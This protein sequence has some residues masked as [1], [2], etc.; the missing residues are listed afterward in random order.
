MQAREVINANH[1]RQSAAR[2]TALLKVLSNPDRL[3]ILCQLTVSEYSV[4][5][6]EGNTGV[7]QP[8]LSQQLGILR[9][10]KLVSTRRVGKQIFYRLVSDDAYA[11][12][13]LLDARF[14]CHQENAESDTSSSNTENL[15]EISRLQQ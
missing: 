9:Q 7:M 2:A 6:L 5:E 10:E 4:G 13:Q 14:A 11:I 8:T 1:M 15:D 12:M 3:L